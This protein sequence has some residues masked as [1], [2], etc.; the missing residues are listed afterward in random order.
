MKKIIVYHDTETLARRSRTAGAD[1]NVTYRSI[2][3]FDKKLN[4]GFDE[5][6]DFSKPKIKTVKK[7]VKGNGV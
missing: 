2:D 5:V 6:L 1:E 4:E 3:Q 7:K